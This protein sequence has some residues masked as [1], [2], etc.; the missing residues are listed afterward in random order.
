[1]VETDYGLQHFSGRLTQGLKS[2]L[3][4]NFDLFDASRTTYQNTLTFDGAD[5]AV[6]HNMGGCMGCH[7]V[8]Q[9]GGNDFSFVLGGGRVSEPEAPE[10]TP[11][12]TSNPP[13][14]NGQP[15]APGDPASPGEPPISWIVDDDMK[16]IRHNIGNRQ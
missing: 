10:I 4:A 6:T 3:P 7:G 5:L 13:P 12:G 1:M 8:A 16:V 14:G 9:L 2:D 11:P 15:T